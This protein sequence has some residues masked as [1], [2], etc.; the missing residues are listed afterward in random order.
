MIADPNRIEPDL[1]GGP[2]H[3]R[4]LR[5]SDDALDFGQLNTNAKRA[6]F[7]APVGAENVE[8][9]PILRYWREGTPHI[10]Q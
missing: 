6:H 2:S 1:F 5:P 9:P 3:R 7:S 8:D 4:I 10:A